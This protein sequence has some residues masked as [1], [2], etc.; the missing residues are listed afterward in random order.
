MRIIW[1]E[2]KKIFDLKIVLILVVFTILFYR[3]F[4]ELVYINPY[5]DRGVRGSWDNY[6]FAAELVKDFGPKVATSDMWKLEK[7]RDGMKAEFTEVIKKNEILRAAGIRDYDEMIECESELLNKKYDENLEPIEAGLTEEEKRIED[8]IE[9]LKYHKQ[10]QL[11][12]N[13]EYLEDLISRWNDIFGMTEAQAEEILQREIVDIDGEKTAYTDEELE[14]EREYYKKDYVSLL[15]FYMFYLIS[16]DLPRMSFLITVW[17]FALV[18]FYQIR[19]RLRGTL[20]MYAATN[21]G[22]KIFSRQFLA[23]IFSCAAVGILHLLVYFGIMQILGMGPLLGCEAW[24]FNGPVTWCWK[25]SFGMYLFLYAMLLLL[26]LLA[27][28]VVIYLIGRFSSNY[29]VGIAVS[30]P[31]ALFISFGNTYIFNGLFSNSREWGGVSEY[32][33]GNIGTFKRPYWE[34]PIIISW[35]VVMVGLISWRMWR[36][37]K[38][39]L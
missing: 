2:C 24:S 11:E 29:I 9:D 17:F 35:V 18:I 28:V 39:D 14:L 27:G 22:R 20:P 16:T 23:C 6:P 37:R 36:D 1:E 21:T 10:S 34:L 3:I 31:A 15:P 30:I 7:K 12:N 26:F 8:E 25:L 33:V 38:I 4:I 13:I 5:A 19:E 32:I